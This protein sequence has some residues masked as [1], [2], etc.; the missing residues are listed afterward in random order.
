M[1]WLWYTCYVTKLWSYKK[2]VLWSN[3]DKM[4]WWGSLYMPL[5]G[6]RTV[7]WKARGGILKKWNTEKIL[8][9]FPPLVATS[10]LC[11]CRCGLL[12]FSD[13]PKKKEKY[14]TTHMR[15]LS[16]RPSWG[17]PT[18]GIL[19]PK[20]TVLGPDIGLFHFSNACNMLQYIVFTLNTAK[21]IFWI[22]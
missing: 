22:S 2:I 14:E 16:L 7:L 21:C 15:P 1:K 6:N 18:F 10:L 5:K 12:G 19:I 20:N 9:F 4:N 3:T 8:Q 17:L 13:Y 11:F